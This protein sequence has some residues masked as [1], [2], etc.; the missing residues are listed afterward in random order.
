MASWCQQDEESAS[1]GILDGYQIDR[2]ETIGQLEPEAF[3]RLRSILWSDLHS[4]GCSLRKIAGLFKVN[5]DLVARAIKDVPDHIRVGR[6]PADRYFDR[7]RKVVESDPGNLKE[8]AERMQREAGTFG[9]EGGIL[10]SINIRR[11]SVDT[12]I[13]MPRKTRAKTPKAD[14]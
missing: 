11:S 7:L 5:K 8:F 9:L 4:V 3:A 1:H 2:P 10:E 13:G 14:S 12:I 6:A